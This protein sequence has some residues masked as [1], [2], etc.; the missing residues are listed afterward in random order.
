MIVLK[1]RRPDGTFVAEVNGLPYHVVEGDEPLWSK[2]VVE[3]ARLGDTLQA[4]PATVSPEPIA[5]F[6]PSASVSA[7]AELKVDGDEISGVETACNVG[8]AMSPDVGLYWVFFSHPEP[9]PAYLAFVQSPGFAADVTLRETDFFEINVTNRLTGEPA[10]PVSL[11][12]SVQR[13]K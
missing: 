7:M 9:D 10:M 4:D 2:A 1:W 3:A 5:V 11:S 12:I 6:P 8:A 13:V